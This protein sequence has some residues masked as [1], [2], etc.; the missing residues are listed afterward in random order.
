VEAVQLPLVNL[1]R[2]GFFARVECAGERSLGGSTVGSPVLEGGWRTR[3]TSA[4][5]TIQLM[6]APPETLIA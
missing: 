4:L 3:S 2:A 5:G 6:S 1:A